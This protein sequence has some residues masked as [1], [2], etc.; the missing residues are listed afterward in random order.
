MPPRYTRKQQLTNQRLLELYKM[1]PL[2]ADWSTV[3]A[4]VRQ[5]W[6]DITINVFDEFKSKWP[7]PGVIEA[8]QLPK[9]FGHDSFGSMVS[10]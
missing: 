10:A 1:A 9:L 2:L 4:D 8:T 6:D 3:D 7:L 5:I